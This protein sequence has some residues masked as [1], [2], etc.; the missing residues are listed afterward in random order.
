MVVGAGRGPLVDRAMNAAHKTNI[1]CRI[2]AI[3]KNSNA[4][5]TLRKRKENEW[6]ERVEVVH[7]D[8]RYWNAKEKVRYKT[9][10]HLILLKV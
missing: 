7:T 8:M 9:L 4:I 5:V 6:K 2:Y 3:E 10:Q 1:K